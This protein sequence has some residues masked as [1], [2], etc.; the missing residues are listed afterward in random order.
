MA[1]IA[2]ANQKGA[3]ALRYSQGRAMAPWIEEQRK[4]GRAECELTWENF[5]KESRRG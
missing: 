4:H 3:E 1:A 2:V 5:F